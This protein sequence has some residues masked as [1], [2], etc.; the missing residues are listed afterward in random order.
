VKRFAAAI[1]A[2]ALAAGGCGHVETGTAN[3]LRVPVTGGAVEGISQDGVAAFKGIPYAAPPTG[4]LR[5]R[6]PQPVAAWKSVKEAKAYGAIC[7]QTY[8]AADEGV[9]P[10]PAS[11]DCLTLN[12][13]APKG[14]QK[15]PVM[16]WIHG[17]G[18]VNGSGT[19]ALYDGANLARQGVVVVTLNYRL[20]RLGFFA[21]PAL[22]AEARDEAVGNYA[23]MDMIQALKWVQS[24]IAAFGGDVGRV[25]I[26]GESAGGVA[27]ND[28]MVSPAARGLFARAI[29][30]SGLGREVMLPLVL[31]ERAGEKFAAEIGITDATAADLRRL[32]PDRILKAGD[33]DLRAGGGAMLDGKIL[34][35][36]PMAG[37]EEG[38]QAPVPYIVGSNSLELPVPEEQLQLGLSAFLS[39]P[40]RERLASVYEDSTTFNA[41]VLS[42]LIFNEPGLTLARLHASRGFPAWA[43]QFSVVSSS[44]KDKLKGAPHASE[45]KYV[46][47]TLATSSW[48]TDDNDAAQSAFMSNYWLAFAKAGDP[49][50]GARPVWPAYDSGADEI[51]DFKND[52]PVRTKIPRRAAMDVL[53]D[54]A[55]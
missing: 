19:A 5:W 18:F 26:F 33:P 22:T 46:F 36:G 32:T 43:Y 42:D 30:Q 49:N 44:M 51:L 3:F 23:L 28:L 27:V 40:D 20:G 16:V 14:A 6:A 2:V 25:T 4:D 47:R 10:L 34:T 13:F 48:P 15:L 8:N 54:I 45:R 21:H 37:F 1:L 35:V 39:T 38:L 11:E 55:K 50:G 24:N 17:G 12:V 29:T 9:G 53:A 52:G 7:P 31:A 41:Y